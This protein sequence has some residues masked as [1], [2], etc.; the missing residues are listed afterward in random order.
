M[1]QF[2]GSGEGRTMPLSEDEQRQLDQIERDLA[3]NP[4]SPGSWHLGRGA[5][6]TIPVI[7]NDERAGASARFLLR[8][9]AGSSAFCCSSP[10]R[11]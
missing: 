5:R 6:L 9:P 1:E 4:S 8:G 7:W 2:T 3:Q 10:A 11:S